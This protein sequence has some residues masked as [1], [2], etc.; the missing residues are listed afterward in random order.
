MSESGVRFFFRLCESEN[1]DGTSTFIPNENEDEWIRKGLTDSDFQC[2]STPSGDD[3]DW[4]FGHMAA[5]PRFERQGAPDPGDVYQYDI[6]RG[7]GFV[8]KKKSDGKQYLVLYP[9]EL[10]HLTDPDIVRRIL[11]RAGPA[12]GKRGS[13]IEGAAEVNIAFSIDENQEMIELDLDSSD[14]TIVGDFYIHS[15]GLRL[16]RSSLQKC[17]SSQRRSVRFKP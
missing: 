9:R 11:P 10:Q 17:L 15:T 6:G 14:F 3:S 2:S 8:G 12:G 13:P 7:A 1:W 4:A 5:D 16:N